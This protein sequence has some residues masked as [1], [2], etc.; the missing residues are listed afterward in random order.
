[1][2]ITHRY[3]HARKSTSRDFAPRIVDGCF[4]GQNGNPV[5]QKW[6]A[7]IVREPGT[8]EV[9]GSG[10]IDAALRYRRGD[11]ASARRGGEPATLL[12]VAPIRV[13]RDRAMTWASPNR[14][15]QGQAA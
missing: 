9:G 13:K 10:L 3:L 2:V 11:L 14:E 12:S 7:I 5:W 1:V 15:V 6:F 8:A 4:R